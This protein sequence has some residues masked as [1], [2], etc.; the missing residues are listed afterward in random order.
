MATLR[1][2]FV[3]E[4]NDYFAQFSALLVRLDAT[5]GDP[6]EL[7]RLA[8]GLRGGAQLARETR[9]LRAAH[10][11][12]AAA[13]AVVGGTLKWNG[14]TSGRV[15][16]TLEDLQALV[17]GGE[18]DDAADA[19]VKRVLDRWNEVNVQPPSEVIDGTATPAAER[20]LASKQFRE[21]AAHEVAGIVAEI[22]SG[23][24]QLASDPRNRETLKSILR[25]QRALLGAA[26]LDEINIVAETL[27]A[28]EDLVRV[29]IKLNVA[30]KDEWAAVFRAAREVLSAAVEP[31]SQGTDPAPLPALSKLRTLR[32]EL[33]ERYGEGEAVP[34][35]GAAPP[36]MAVS[37]PQQTAL[38]TAVTTA[39]APAA[40]SAN[41]AQPT[42]AKTTA[43]AANPAMA[44]APAAI[45][46]ALSTASTPAA[47]TPAASTPAASTSAATTP[48]TPSAAADGIVPIEDLCYTGE[49]ALR[50]ALE[51]A[52]EIENLAGDKSEARD[53]VEEVFDL[54]R[55]GIG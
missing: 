48:T 29:I 47:S 37:T 22:E 46:P 31:L 8:K 53:Y 11:L 20:S 50:R 25:R 16:R 55:L 51:L 27:R 14:D 40:E 44:A 21:F 6:N 18:D 9:V 43:P 28:I 15:R 5:R 19:R 35:T 23:L 17:A 12:E 1:D 7:V 33:L 2:Y 32:S 42:D 13:R 39:S 45:T 49:R 24:N 38:A 52:P 26:R 36:G 4:S 10:G 30:V 54:I 34:V 3:T 41:P